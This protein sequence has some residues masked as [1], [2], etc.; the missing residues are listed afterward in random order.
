MAIKGLQSHYEENKK[1]FQVLSEK[2]CETIINASFSILEKTG[3]ILKDAE[4]VQL[5]VDN[6]ASAEGELVKIPKELLINSI[7][8]AASELVLYDRLGNKRIVASGTN[9]YFGLG[10]TN[11]YTNDVETGEIRSSLRA[12]VTRSA[13]VA[14]ACPNI[15]FVMGLSQIS[16]C[17]VNISDIY[18]GYEMLTNTIKPAIIWGINSDNLDVQVQ[19]ADTIAGGHDKLVEKPFIALFPGCPVT[20]SK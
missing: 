5:L 2:D 7:N 18:E 3:I 6:G 4:A 20:P 12:D 11:P 19:M 15:D 8:S 17:N 9:T 16:D 1:K 13:T 10:P 14:D